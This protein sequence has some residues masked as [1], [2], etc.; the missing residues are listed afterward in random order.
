MLCQRCHVATRHPAIDLRQGRNHHEQEQPHVRTVVREL[1]LECPRVESPVGPVLHAVAFGGTHAPA[2]VLI[3]LVCCLGLVMP[4]TARA[5]TTAKPPSHDAGAQTPPIRRPSRKPEPAAP[6]AADAA[7]D[8]PRSLFELTG[9]SSHSAAASAASTATR[10]DSSGIGISATALLFTDARYAREHPDGNCAVQRAARQRRLARPAVL[11]RLRADGPLRHLGPAGTRFRSSTASTPRRP[12]TGSAAARWCWTTRRSGPSRT[13]QAT[14]SAYVPIAPQFDL[15]R[16]PRHRQRD[17]LA[18]PTPQLDVTAFVHDQ[19]HV[20]E[21]PWGASFGFSNDVEVA[22]P[23]DSRANDFTL[24][25]EW[26]N[27][28]TCFAS[29]TT[30]RGSTTSTIARLG[31]PAAAHRRGRRT[32]AAGGWRCG[33]RTRRRRSASAATRKLA[34]RTQLTGFLS[35]GSWSNDEPLQPFTINAGAPAARAAASRPTG[36]SRTSF[37]PT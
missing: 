36:A 24:G 26:T 7:D 11:R 2:L 28:A 13:A 10:R 18:T 1:P 17:F 19:R 29:P 8:V 33:R 15:A 35:F 22:L 12:I 31:Q 9:R 32:R 37:R 16:A 34:R 14:L 23:Y 30:V 20:G 3:R 5:Q 27:H 25:A 21:L 6:A 4:A